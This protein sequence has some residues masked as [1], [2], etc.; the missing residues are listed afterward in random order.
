M[1]LLVVETLIT[2][3]SGRSPD[4]GN[5]YGFYPYGK[6]AGT[7]VDH[8]KNVPTAFFAAT[9]SELY[10]FVA[11]DQ[12]LHQGILKKCSLPL[13]KLWPWPT[14][15]RHVNFITQMRANRGTLFATYEKAGGV[16][17]GLVP[18][19][20]PAPKPPAQQKEMS[21]EDEDEDSI[22]RAFV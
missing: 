10:V 20:E 5:K 17:D 7:S 1:C 12:S 8:F 11:K 21:S 9:L 15:S 2:V 16:Y 3:A 18:A 13:T 22:D 19:P 4:D 14:V 6:S